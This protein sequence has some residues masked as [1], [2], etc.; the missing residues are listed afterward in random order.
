MYCN[1]GVNRRLYLE[2]EVPDGDPVVVP[3]RRAEAVSRVQCVLGDV[4]KI[5]NVLLTRRTQET[6]LR[7]GKTRW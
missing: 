2:E 3:G 6:L 7:G 4:M 5:C 1:P